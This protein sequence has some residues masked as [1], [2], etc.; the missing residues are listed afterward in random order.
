MKKSNSNPTPIYFQL[1]QKLQK[2]I[3]NGEWEPRARIPSE[4][5]LAEVYEVSLG[6]VNKA[7]LNLV[8]L[9]YLYRIQGKGTFVT[10]TTLHRENLHY[11]RFLNDFGNQEASIRMKFIDLKKIDGIERVNRLLKI[12]RKNGLYHLKR[13][14]IQNKK[15][16]IYTDSFFPQKMFK[17]L[18]KFTKYQFERIP[19]FISLEKSYN[20]TT[21]FNSELFSVA[22][23]IPLEVREHLKVPKGKPT[24]T[25]RYAG[26]YFQRKTL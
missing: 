13:L 11:Y 10:S 16:I 5:H 4:K 24:F 26:F 7:I 6:T 23:D 8:N 2:E 25:N 1:Q 21:I 18:E 9:G 22:T 17:D 20:V 14:F 12:R 19:I 3:E 15:P